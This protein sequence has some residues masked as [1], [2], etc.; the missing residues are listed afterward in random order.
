MYDKKGELDKLQQLSIHKTECPDSLEEMSDSLTD[1][2]LT[3]LTATS[4]SEGN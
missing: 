3:S 2:E 1:P 4:T